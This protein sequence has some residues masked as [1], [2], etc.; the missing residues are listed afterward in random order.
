MSSASN[1]QLVRVV[2]LID[3]LDRRGAVDQLLAPVRQ[4]LALLRPPRPIT[5]GRVMI[6]PFED[7]LVA[8]GEAWPGRLCFSRAHLA[9]LV[10]QV[11]SE[12]PADLTGRLRAMAAE[13]SMIAGEVVRAIGAELW[14][15][16]AA[17]AEARLVQGHIDPAVRQQLAA[18]TPLMA[19][20]PQLV[21]VIWRLPARPMGPL[22][23]S[24]L[25]PF[26]D[27]VRLATT[28]GEAAVQS[29]LELLLTRAASPL[30]VLEPLRTAEL[31]M[32]HR[33]REAM[34]AQLVHRRIADMS[35]AASR[36]AAAHTAG[37]RPDAGSL[38]R[39][40]GDLDVLE[41]KWFV[42]AEQRVRL[43]EIRSTV[44]AFI[45]GGIE[46]V[47]QEEILGPLEALA[48]GG[49]LSD[50]GVEHLEETARHTRRL[51]VAGAKLGLAAT[52]DALLG[53]FLPAC[54]E[55]VRAGRA[56]RRAL[57]DQIRVVEILF[58]S[59]AAARLYDEL[60]SGM[61]AKAAD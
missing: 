14:P 48:Q 53:R 59:D 18:V 54:Q 28:L 20:G 51:S 30:V 43:G 15:A 32:S 11:T 29:V 50:E 23:R 25:G 7:L 60:R 40:V 56:G 35:E 27:A 10:E 49:T 2:G 1:E 26:L 37:R 34:L 46:S 36:L 21:P 9:W 58:G 33:A 61:A 3:S 13:H 19:L 45:G 8:G 22:G 42:P 31:S 47:V 16:A 5:L 39:L 12:L 57:L 6:L 52:A 4:R 55:A 38:L 44:S 17:T 24:G 41:S